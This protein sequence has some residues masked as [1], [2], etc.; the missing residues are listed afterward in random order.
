[1][2]NSKNDKF[3][4]GSPRV[5]PDAQLRKYRTIGILGGMGPAAT[6]DLMQKIIDATPAACD[7]EH[8]PMIVWNVP[9]IP[10]RGAF[11]AGG[12]ISPCPSMCAGAKALA[13]AGAD[14]IVIACNTAH[15]FANEVAAAANR[16]L[17]HIADT[18]L[19]QLENAHIGSAMLLA[20]EGTHRIGI[21]QHRAAKFGITLQKP[22]AISQ[23]EITAA[24]ASVKAGNIASARAIILP[25][26]NR[27]NTQGAATF[28]LACTEL[29]LIVRGTSFEAKSVDATAALAIEI[30][31]FSTGLPA[32]STH[33]PIK[34][35]SQKQETTIGDQVA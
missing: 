3:A 13:D 26:L 29:P 35:A 11:I 31:K 25:V 4:I 19:A 8:V 30:V 14:A 12:D 16:P 9:Q 32:R 21:Y 7:Q 1:M 6:V 33:S 28:I 10:D 5:P 15:Q 34:I 24:I 20:T 2:M 18:A 23:A 17:I 22:G 27:L